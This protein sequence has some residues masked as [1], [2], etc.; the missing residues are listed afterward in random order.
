MHPT[1]YRGYLWKEVMQNT[2]SIVY[3]SDIQQPEV[4]EMMEKIR[5]KKPF[6]LTEYGQRFPI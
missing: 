5:D 1:E 3:C 2:S 4:S 6:K